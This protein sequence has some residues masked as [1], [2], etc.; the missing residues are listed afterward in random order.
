MV[1]F[2]LLFML[3]MPWIYKKLSDENAVTASGIKIVL[4]I[5]LVQL[6]FEIF[7]VFLIGILGAALA[8]NLGSGDALLLIIG[9]ALLWQLG[10]VVLIALEIKNPP[11]AQ[12]AQP[13]GTYISIPTSLQMHLPGLHE[14]RRNNNKKAW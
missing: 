1:V 5:E 12:P 3:D 8:V 13:L 9:I 2:A 14:L 10:R 4:L 11:P 7:F 6:S